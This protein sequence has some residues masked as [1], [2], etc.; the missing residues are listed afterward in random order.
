MCYFS[1]AFFLHNDLFWSP[2]HISIQ[3]DWSSVRMWP[4]LGSPWPLVAYLEGGTRKQE[5]RDETGMEEKSI[6]MM[7]WSWLPLWAIRTQSLVPLWGAVWMYPKVSPPKGASIGHLSTDFWLILVESCP[8]WFSIPWTVPS[9]G[10]DLPFR[11]I[12]KAEN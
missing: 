11:K 6:K 5:W 3:G 7:S 9:K 10:W 8:S 1:F 12:P 2:C 4:S